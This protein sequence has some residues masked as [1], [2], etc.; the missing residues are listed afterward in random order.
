MATTADD[1]LTIGEVGIFF[2]CQSWKI[3]RLI[4]LGK[5]QEGRRVGSVAIFCR[6]EL[7]AI[8]TALR[9]AGY[10]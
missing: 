8:E 1:V 3:R 5:I 10:L 7:P 9:N 4:R 6:G 2:G